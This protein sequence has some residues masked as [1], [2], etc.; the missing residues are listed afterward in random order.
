[1][2]KRSYDKELIDRDDI[3]FT[4]IR[5]NLVELNTINTLLGGHRITKKGVTF[6][7]KE[8]KPG[9]PLAIAEIGCGGGDNLA[10]IK[11]FLDKKGIEVNLTGIDIK[12]ECILYAQEKNDFNAT[13]TC[14][15]YRKTRWDNGK[16]DIV[17]SSLFCHHFTDEQLVEQLTWLK[18]NSR[19]GF[20]INDLHRN[21]IAY[22]AI[23]LLSCLFSKSYLVKNDA[24]LSVKRGF[25]K[26]E[27][28]ELLQKAG[29]KKYRVSW[30]WA[31][32]YLICVTN[33]PGNNI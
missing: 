22:F 32:R 20:F 10:A 18:K 33:E 15:D 4:D 21:S 19:L 31:F 24:P 14:C 17:F 7:L 2:K 16:P 25:K 3:P 6:F 27:W 23:K 26:T 11:D 9:Q 8:L 12:Q 1:M 30:N 29:I 5:Q 28:V 13:W